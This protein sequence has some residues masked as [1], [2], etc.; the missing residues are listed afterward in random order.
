[1]AQGAK[2]WLTCGRLTRALVTITL[3]VMVVQGLTTLLIIHFI[4]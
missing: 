4:R 1:M 3:A 2:Q